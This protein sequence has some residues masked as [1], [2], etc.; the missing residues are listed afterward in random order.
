[1]KTEKMFLIATATMVRT[2]EL[3]MD[4]RECIVL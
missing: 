4:N 1:M 3:G 2:K